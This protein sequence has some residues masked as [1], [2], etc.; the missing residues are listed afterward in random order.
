VLSE[1]EHAFLNDVQRG[2]FVANVIDGALEGS[3]FDALQEIG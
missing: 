1:L 2:L 3:L